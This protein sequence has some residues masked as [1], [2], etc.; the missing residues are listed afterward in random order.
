MQRSI[1]D[2]ILSVW[3]LDET[4]SQLFDISS[5]LKQKLRSNRRNKMVK[6]YANKEEVTKPPTQ[7][8]FPLLEWPEERISPVVFYAFIPLALATHIPI[9]AC[10]TAWRWCSSWWVRRN[11]CRGVWLA[12]RCKWDV[13][14]SNISLISRTTQTFYHYLVIDRTN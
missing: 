10:I 13:I 3:I 4:L 1:F 12:A 6:I 11:C 7:L 14:Q 9:L 2:E 8:W 5:Q